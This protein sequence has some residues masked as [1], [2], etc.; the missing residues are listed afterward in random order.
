MNSDPPLFSAR[1]LDPNFFSPRGKMLSSSSAIKRKSTAPPPRPT[2][3]VGSLT[4]H[5]NLQRLKASAPTAPRCAVCK[6]LPLDC[7]CAVIFRGPVL[8]ENAIDHLVHALKQT[9]SKSEIMQLTDALVEI[10]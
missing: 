3:K 9:L 5:A 7:N 8:K 1:F 2:K 10:P 6:N 4:P